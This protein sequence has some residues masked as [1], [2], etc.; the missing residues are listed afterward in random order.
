MI[1][2]GCMSCFVHFDHNSVHPAAGSQAGYV[3]RQEQIRP[4]IDARGVSADGS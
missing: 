4:D 2:Y 1:T 3:E